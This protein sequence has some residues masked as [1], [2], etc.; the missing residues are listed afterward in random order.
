MLPLVKQVAP[1]N[2]YESLLISLIYLYY[3]SFSESS[4]YDTHQAFKEHD[5]LHSIL[6]YFKKFITYITVSALY[7]WEK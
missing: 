5:V 6:Q 7:E 4:K 2:A 1:G 3:C